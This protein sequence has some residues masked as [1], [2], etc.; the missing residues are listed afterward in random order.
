MKYVSGYSVL[1]N[2]AETD[3]DS[4]GDGDGCCLEE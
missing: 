4:D 1:Q 3:P 2:E